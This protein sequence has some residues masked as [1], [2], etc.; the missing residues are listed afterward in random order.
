MPSPA[1]AI[2]IGVILAAALLVIATTVKSQDPAAPPEPVWEYLSVTGSVANTATRTGAFSQS[3]TSSA[4]ICF[5]TTQGCQQ[6]P[7]TLSVGER[8]IGGEALASAI[9]Q[10]GAEGWELTTASETET[11]RIMYFKRLKSNSK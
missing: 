2:Q 1:R 9:A 5:I 8:S 11:G 4:M 3:Y 10:V 6:E 7:V